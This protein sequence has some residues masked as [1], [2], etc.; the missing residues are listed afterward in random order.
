MQVAE[1]QLKNN[2]L[3]TSALS[4]PIVPI[5]VRETHSGEMRKTKPTASKGQHLMVRQ[6][7]ER[8]ESPQ[9]KAD[10]AVLLGRHT[11]PSAGREIT[12]LRQPRKEGTG[13]PAK[14][15]DGQQQMLNSE[16]KSWLVSNKPRKG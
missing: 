16:S 3:T 8:T 4:L 7:N 13:Q 2:E 1:N 5:T 11:G 12:V 10:S 15:M 6:A 9:H 14:Q